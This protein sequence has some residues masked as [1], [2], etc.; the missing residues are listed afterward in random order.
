MC[1]VSFLERGKKERKGE[2]RRVIKVVEGQ[3][4]AGKCLKDLLS[5]REAVSLN[6]LVVD[7]LCN[8]NQFNNSATFFTGHYFI[9]HLTTL[10][11]SSIT[12]I[13]S[14]KYIAHVCLYSNLSSLICF[15]LIFLPK[16][17]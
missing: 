11:L 5:H 8:V 2:G 9:L 12:C 13:L 7:N 4:E 1:R 6:V 14:S 15:L 3:E 10:I 17:T 16:E